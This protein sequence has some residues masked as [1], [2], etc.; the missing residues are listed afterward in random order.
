[1]HSSDR[2]NNNQNQELHPRDIL[3]LYEQQ[4]QQQAPYN[5]SSSS[6]SATSNYLRSSPAA[7]DDE[8]MKLFI[9]QVIFIGFHNL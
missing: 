3:P 6:S 2:E 5:H 1:M 4:Y 9:G 8:G 7:D